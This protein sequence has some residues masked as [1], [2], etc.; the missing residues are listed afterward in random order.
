M[1]TTQIE[2]EYLI[3]TGV[4]R[5]AEEFRGIF[6]IET[7]RRFTD[8]SRQT[9]FGVRVGDYVPTSSIASHANG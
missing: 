7:I 4:E 8:E 3:R 5:L 9:L 2:H 1:S 6:G